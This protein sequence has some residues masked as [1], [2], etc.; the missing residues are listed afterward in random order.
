M[1]KIDLKKEIKI[2]TA[3]IKAELN[4][5]GFS[6]LIVGLSGGIDSAVTAALSVKAIGKENVFGV[7]M[8]Y[9]NSH[10]NSLNDA[11]KLAEILNIQTSSQLMLMLQ[12]Q[13]QFFL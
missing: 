13:L 2:I 11:E 3:F 1:R 6:K 4:N 7:M 10:P 12:F 9:R 5:T 8:P